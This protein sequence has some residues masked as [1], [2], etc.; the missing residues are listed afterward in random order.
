LVFLL[1]I[2]LRGLYPLFHQ[3][4]LYLELFHLF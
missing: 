2:L 4:L 1:C 3:Y